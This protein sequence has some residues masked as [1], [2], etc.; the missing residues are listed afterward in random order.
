MYIHGGRLVAFF[1]VLLAGA[2]ADS[3]NFPIIHDKGISQ[4]GAHDSD[5]DPSFFKG[6]F[7]N[8]GPSAASTSISALRVDDHDDGQWVQ[9]STEQLKFLR[10]IKG[11][12]RESVEESNRVQHQSRGKAEGEA[13]KHTSMRRRLVTTVSDETAFNNAL[14]TDSEI[15]MAADIVLAATVTIS[16]LTGVVIN[17]RGFKVDGN[18]TVRCFYISSAEVFF[19]N[20]TI[21]DGQLVRDRQSQSARFLCDCT[22]DSRLPLHRLG[23]PTSFSIPVYSAH[24]P[25]PAS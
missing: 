13:E 24:P 20:L 21:A 6:G 19:S 3:T 23:I 15:E 25:T 12:F 8:D 9:L 11:F 17:G 16:G 7:S 14:G 2:S 22:N 1:G 10:S 5:P 18:S 4:G